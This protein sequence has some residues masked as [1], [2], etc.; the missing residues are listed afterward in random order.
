MNF[1]KTIFNFLQVHRA[2]IVATLA[3]LSSL[4]LQLAYLG[5]LISIKIPFYKTVSNTPQFFIFVGIIMFTVVEL[6]VEILNS[7]CSLGGDLV[8]QFL[9]IGSQTTST[10]STLTTSPI[11]L[12]IKSEGIIDPLVGSLPD[13]SIPQNNLDFYMG[14]TLFITSVIAVIKCIG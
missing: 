5:R 3:G 11:S 10:G 1:F 14:V 9:K 7:L 8:A 2:L 12:E 6:R 4:I 13:P